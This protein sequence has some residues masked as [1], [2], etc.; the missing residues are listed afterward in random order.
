MGAFGVLC[1]KGMT[2]DQVNAY[3]QLE[4]LFQH[5]A[6]SF[7][8]DGKGCTPVIMFEQVSN[9]NGIVQWN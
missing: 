2:G 6:V 9:M 4:P 3:D 1:L 7:V 5:I 8:E